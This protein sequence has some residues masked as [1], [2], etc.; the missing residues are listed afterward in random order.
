MFTGRDKALFIWFFLLVPV[1]LSAFIFKLQ[2]T[3]PDIRHINIVMPPYNAVPDDETDDSPAFQLALND[4]KKK[5]G[6]VLFIPAG[7]YHF[8]EIVTI[9]N[10]SW[11][12]MI[13][14][15]SM[16][17]RLFC[18]NSNG[19]FRLT[20]TAR[21][22]EVTLRNLTMTADFAGAG[23]AFEI[24]SP[25][26]GANSKRI[27]I[28]DNILITNRTAA[29]FFTKGIT[30]AGI[31]RPL[32]RN[33]EIYGPV[34]MDDV[35]DSSA[36][37]QMETGID[38]SDSY[39]PVIE[40]C[41]VSGVS[42]AYLFSALPDSFPEDGAVRNSQVDY[43]RTG[44]I[45]RLTS[46]VREPTL[47]V[48]DCN[49]RSRDCSVLIESRR[50]FH[51]TGNTF[52]Q[53]SENHALQDIHLKDCHLG[54]IRNNVFEQNTFGMRKNLIIDAGGLDII[55]AGNVWS[56]STNVVLDISPEAEDVFLY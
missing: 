5:G 10:G 52:R 26:G 41:R 20:H 56:D 38:I 48:T 54:I 32:I 27:F 3:V 25:P 55:I 31:Y 16:D 43:C 15:E 13:R 4:L 12:L 49:F 21:K 2:R 45:F 6:G 22:E 23:T 28:A 36:N 1:L 53:L 14:G 35:S 11:G 39:A 9:T 51:I 8:D 18:R 7:D 24:T 46:G 17:S 34:D 29:G 42:T 47:W 33:C 50:I 37:F 19:I 44:M 40:N 30:A